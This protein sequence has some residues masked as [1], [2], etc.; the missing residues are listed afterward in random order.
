MT[1]TNAHGSASAHAKVTNLRRRD[2][3]A[4]K[5]SFTVELQSGLRLT[6]CTLLEKNGE[7]WI[8]FPSRSYTG[9]DGTTKYVPYVSFTT[10]EAKARFQAMVLPLVLEAMR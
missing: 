2:Q 9:E 4:A 8:G 5:A 3:G 1:Y 7:R 6:D 10:P